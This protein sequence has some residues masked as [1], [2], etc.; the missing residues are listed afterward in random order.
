MKKTFLALAAALVAAPALAATPFGDHVSLSG[1]GTVGVVSS[2]NDDVDFVRD[3]SPKGAGRRESWAVDSKLG[4]QADIKATSWLSATFQV[5]AEQRYEPGVKAD[6]EW[7]FVTLKPVDGL[8]VRLGRTSPTVFAVSD[9]RNVG[10]AN[11]T[12]RM[13]N[14]VYSL[15]TLKRLHGVDASYRANVAGTWLTV[16]AM[17]GDGR[18][19]TARAP[20][21]GSEKVRGLNV[22]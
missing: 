6:L 10:Y 21:L 18:T 11:T 15:N 12:I 14:E 3:G 1:F 8:S 5:L 2:D 19:G 9:S 22:V 16:S 13:P 4:I 7:G 17:A 20:S